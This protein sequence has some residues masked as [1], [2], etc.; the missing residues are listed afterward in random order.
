MDK[1][2]NLNTSGNLPDG[3]AASQAEG[4]GATAAEKRKGFKAIDGHRDPIWTE[5]PNTPTPREGAES[6]G[7]DKVGGFCGRPQGWQR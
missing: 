7:M 3:T 5:D 6:M 1:D 2:L 4:F